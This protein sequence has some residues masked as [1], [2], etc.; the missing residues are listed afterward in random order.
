MRKAP[1]ENFFLQKM[2]SLHN[3]MPNSLKS[4]AGKQ[5]RE[6]RQ[7]MQ[8]WKDLCA[9]VSKLCQKKSRKKKKWS[10]EIAI[11]TFHNS[12]FASGCSN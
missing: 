8:E 3:H 7:G 9:V 1:C 2:T 11:P 6:A 5:D 12:N 4:K 10:D